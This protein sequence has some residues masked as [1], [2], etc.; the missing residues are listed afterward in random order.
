MIKLLIIET[1]KIVNSFPTFNTRSD[2]I[3]V[4]NRIISFVLIS[5]IIIKDKFYVIFAL[6]VKTWVKWSEMS[7][8]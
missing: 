2:S 6:S 7:E 4:V 5:I 8:K 3:N 1:N